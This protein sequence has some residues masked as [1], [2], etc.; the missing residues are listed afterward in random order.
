[1]VCRGIP[2][3]TLLLNIVGGYSSASMRQF[4]CV[5]KIYI[6][7]RVMRKQTIC[8][9]E[10]K[11]ADQ[12]RGLRFRHIGSTIPLLSKPLTIFCDCT[13]WFVS[14]Q[15]GNQNVGFLMTRLNYILSKGFM[16][17]RYVAERVFAVQTNCRKDKLFFSYKIKLFYTEMVYTL[18]FCL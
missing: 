2:F 16:H 14:D 17:V 1:M 8:I 7:S 11:D 4:N 5:P 12:L 6:L 3:L 18:Y 9:C 10:N 13:A 15:V